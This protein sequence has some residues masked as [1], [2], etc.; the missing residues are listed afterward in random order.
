MKEESG[1]SVLIPDHRLHPG[2]FSPPRCGQYTALLGS[3]KLAPS[4]ST[5][6]LSLPPSPASPTPAPAR[7]AGQ[8]TPGTE[9]V[10]VTISETRHALL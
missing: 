6:L 1:N 3:W 10:E 7:E 8:L 4:S 5:R 9:M 2:D